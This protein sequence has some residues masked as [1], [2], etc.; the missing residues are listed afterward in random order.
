MDSIAE[1]ILN[2]IP[3]LKGLVSWAD[4]TLTAI[5]AWGKVAIPSIIILAGGLGLLIHF[6]LLPNPLGGEEDDDNW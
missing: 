2:A 4:I 6:K 5:P 1:I 3:W